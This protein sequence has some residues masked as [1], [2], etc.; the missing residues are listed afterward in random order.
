MRNSRLLSIGLAAVLAGAT[1]SQ[2]DI[3]AELES[4]ANVQVVSGVS[5]FRGWAFSEGEDEEE[6]NVQ[7]VIDGVISEGSLWRVVAHGKTWWIC[8][9][10]G[11]GWTADLARW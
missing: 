8:T 5:L 10:P 9:E 1:V 2:A 11:R 6:V 4:P 7:L 3:I